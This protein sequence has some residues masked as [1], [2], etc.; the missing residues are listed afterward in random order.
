ML[1]RGRLDQDKVRYVSSV[2]GKVAR[3]KSILY[4]I[5]QSGGPAIFYALKIRNW[6]LGLGSIS[7]VLEKN[8]VAFRTIAPSRNWMIVYVVDLKGDL[9]NRIRASASQL[10]ATVSAIEGVSEFIGSEVSFSE[11]E[12]SYNRVINEIESRHPQVKGP[13]RIKNPRKG[14]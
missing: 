4:F 13:C 3:Q 11:A 12:Q 7:A 10:H 5:P 6:N 14:N 8:G 9:V 1:I 2:L